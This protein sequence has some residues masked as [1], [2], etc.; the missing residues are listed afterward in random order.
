[1]LTLLLDSLFGIEIGGVPLLVTGSVLTVISAC[2]AF[3]YS[4][5]CQES[6]FKVTLSDQSVNVFTFLETVS[7]YFS[8]GTIEDSQKTLKRLI[9]SPESLVLLDRMYRS[10]IKG[11]VAL[12]Q[13]EYLGIE[14]TSQEY[15]YFQDHLTDMETL[16]KTM[17]GENESL[18]LDV[19]ELREIAQY[20]DFYQLYELNGEFESLFEH[21]W[22]QPDGFTS[23]HLRESFRQL[24]ES[25]LDR[26]FDIYANRV[27]NHKRLSGG[28]PHPD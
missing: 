18:M 23:G 10:G 5:R 6:G 28:L 24:S 12:R 20:L 3:L 21:Y 8:D 17:T 1:M 7:D 11:K 27:Y 4:V 15:W 16:I 14:Q 19:S 2:K 9:E 22:Q 13:L 25:L 26:N